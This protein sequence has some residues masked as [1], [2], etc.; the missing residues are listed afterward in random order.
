MIMAI[1]LFSFTAE[2]IHRLVISCNEELV[3]SDN[4]AEEKCGTDK[5]G[6][7]DFPLVVYR[8]PLVITPAKQYAIPPAYLLPPAHT[9]LPE[10][11]PKQIG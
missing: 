2:T 7:N 5:Y 4:E 3:L 6:K 1:V 9:L 8:N 11:P 10:L